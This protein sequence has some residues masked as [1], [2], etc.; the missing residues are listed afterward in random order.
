MCN[1]VSHM[2]CAGLQEE[3]LND[4]MC[5]YCLA[6]KNP[7]EYDE[8]NLLAL[9]DEV[10]PS[11]VVAVAAEN[12]MIDNNK[13][14]ENE[15][16]DGDNVGVFINEV[17]GGV[18]SAPHSLLI[19]RLHILNQTPSY[20]RS[21]NEKEEIDLHI[22]NLLKMKSR[23]EI[24]GKPCGLGTSWTYEKN[25]LENTELVGWPDEDM[26]LKFSLK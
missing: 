26:H 7:S 2:H 24:N 14:C 15:N 11:A 5:A 6:D 22:K 21:D 23:G 1:I 20:R 3:P 25:I 17:E 9:V 19:K 18:P 13:D 4:W 10:E 8:V 12:V 16:I